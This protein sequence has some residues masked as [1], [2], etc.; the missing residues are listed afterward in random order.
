MKRLFRF[1]QPTT[2]KTRDWEPRTGKKFSQS[3]VPNRQFPFPS[4]PLLL[5]LLLC[6]VLVLTLG[7]SGTFVLAQ[8]ES[9]IKQE[10]DK[11]I[12]QYV[13]PSPP[14]KSPVYKP[15]PA[16]PSRKQST[17]RPR[18]E[19]A[20]PAQREAEDAP[21][22]RE[23]APEPPSRRRQN[24]EPEPESQEA[25]VRE[26]E[27]SPA[28][29]RRLRRSEPA[30]EPADK[31]DVEDRKTVPDRESEAVETPRASKPAPDL[32]S[33]TD[34]VAETLPTN[35]YALEFNRSPVVSNRLR[36]RGVYSEARLG[37]T[38]P[39]GW[40]L[41]S[42]KALIRYQ[43]SPALVASRSNL[44]VQVNGTSVGSMPLNRKESQVGQALFNIPAKL[45][46]DYND[47]SIVAQQNNDPKCSDPSDP[48]L[49]TEV[50]PDSKLL[51][52][53][54]PQ[55]IPL[56]LTRYPYPFFDE[57]SLEPNRIV[58]LLP[59]LNEAWLTAAPRFQA[60]LGRLADFRP[61]ETRLVQD[62]DEV[63]P[64]D[65]LIVIG[66]PAAQPALK[67]LDLP[68][69]MAANQILD[70][71]KIPLPDNVGLLMLTTTQKGSVPILVVTGNGSEGVIKAAQFLVQPDTRKL[72]TGQAIVVSDLNKVPT[73]SPRHWPLYLPETNSFK[74]SDLKTPTNGK[75]FKDI[76]VRG[77]SAPP[78][79]F[80]F[81]A[82]PDDQFT[83][84][85]YMNL[86]YSYGPQLNPRLSAVEVLLDDVFIGGA[87]LTSENGATRQTLR[88]DLPANLLKPTS[89]I[90][91]AF[92]L[93]PKEPPECGKV[94]D[95]QLTGTVHADTDFKLNRENS[96][97]L[98]DLELLQ[99][100]FP[101]A[102]PQD[103]SRTAMVVPESP[104]NTELLTLLAFSE[105]LGRLSRSDSIQLKAYTTASL[106]PDISK[107][108][109]LVGIGRRE[110]FPFP[111]VLES[112]G[113]RLLDAFSRQTPQGS[114]QTL[115]D[116]SG[117]I[118]E[119]ISP[120]NSGSA[121]RVLLALS[122]QT[123]EGLE[124]VRQ[125]IS[126]DPWFFQLREDTVLVSSDSS[127]S[128]AYDSD[129]Y[130]LEFLQRAPSTKR[131]ENTNLLGKVI[132]YLQE[133]WFILPVGIVAI[134]L[135]LYGIAQLYLNR[136]TDMKSH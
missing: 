132:R 22:Q 30:R 5:V 34:S 38:R 125:I 113:F 114:I 131:L 36:L 89:K 84:G 62:L 66:T 99:T 81:R 77:S 50:L 47:L 32:T 83:R 65:R 60:A 37:F 41:K 53:Y 56:N 14:T 7:I 91:V 106:T 92:R 25:A 8:N 1:F 12:R 51:F 57:L 72:A 68:F 48:T 33:D 11:L 78:I 135:L 35:K 59:K 21:P 133:N 94:I 4:R 24:V 124:Q 109:H 71:N 64:N 104:S 40:K 100:G 70:G 121:P 90:K 31:P 116:Q 15:A 23:V 108:H 6:G 93:N 123:E 55:P 82:L 117:V 102:A 128:D 110:K 28:P 75:P 18:R 58:Y 87:R 111:K 2:T 45:I 120:E 73:P 80:D 74:L 43:H 105:R 44:T 115:P 126:K 26:T 29:P 69:K 9:S 49:W 112:G 103:L 119:I 122:A 13:L 134:A 96:V 86:R 129:A 52:E 54:Q 17:S 61:I 98:P 76:T 42:V 19:S 27:R 97:Q 130:R 67:S 3:P 63:E 95:Q 20:P 107:S 39:R 127:S 101:F 88:V 79:E 46:Q 10:E 118:K 136:V 16:S 85:S